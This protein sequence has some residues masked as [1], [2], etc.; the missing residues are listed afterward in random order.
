MSPQLKIILISN[1]GG[2]KAFR[3]FLS[4]WGS[5]AFSPE[6]KILDLMRRQGSLCW[7][8]HTIP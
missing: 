5:Q 2:F 3:V 1:Q 7:F 6:D 8:I 4:F